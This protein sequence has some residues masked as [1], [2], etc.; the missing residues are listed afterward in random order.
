M[1]KFNIKVKDVKE[2]IKTMQDLYASVAG[3]KFFIALYAAPNVARYTVEIGNVATSFK[4]LGDAV[5]YFNE[6]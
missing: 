2:H 3:K 5:R 1:K 6:Q 4:K